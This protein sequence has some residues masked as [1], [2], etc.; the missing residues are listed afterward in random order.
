MADYAVD[1]STDNYIYRREITITETGGEGRTNL[2]VKLLFT[3]SNFNF[4]LARSD[5]YDVRVAVSSNGTGV[6]NMWVVSW[7]K[8]EEEGVIWIKIPSL[9][10]DEIKTLYVYWG[11]TNAEYVSNIDDVG[12]LLADHFD[13][14]SI[15]TS[16]W[17]VSTTPT[18]YG[19]SKIV[20]PQSHYMEAKNTPLSG[21]TDWILEEGASVY[22]P[23]NLFGSPSRK[24][25][26]YGSE[27]NF[28][29]WYYREGN[30]D[31][32][33]NIIDGVNYVYYD[34]TQKGI[35]NT[36][37]STMSVAYSESTDRVYQSMKDRNSYV[38]YMDSWERQVYGETK[39]TYFRLYGRDWQAGTGVPWLATEWIVVREFFETDPYSFDTSNLYVPYETVN[40]EIID[41]TSYDDDVTSVNFYHTTNSGG[42]PY[43]LSDNI[44]SVITNCWYSNDNTAFA[45]SIIDF[46]RDNNNIVSTENTH[47]DSGHSGLKNA[48]RLS[49]NDDNT[50]FQGTTSSGYVCIEFDNN[51]AVGCL[52]VKGLTGSLDNMVKDYIF[53][54]SYDDP[55]LSGD[56]EIFSSGSFQQVDEEQPIYFVNGTPYKY[57][58]LEMLNT[59]G[60]GN[61]ILS[62]WQMYQYDESKRKMTVSQLRLNPVA[63]DS[64]EIYF[65]KAV[66]VEVSDNMLD[67]TELLPLT[68]TVTPF[69]DYIWNRWQRFSFT[70][71]TGYYNYKLICYG[72]WN[73]YSGPMAIAEWEMV[74][75]SSEGHA[76]RVLAGISNDFSSVWASTDTT[77]DEGFIYIGDGGFLNTV[78]NDSLVS[79]TVVSGIVDINLI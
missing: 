69:Y 39:I 45:E 33:H 20:M 18:Y 16:K 37:S 4:R 35:E 63:F 64:Q 50:Y 56:W 49:D 25:V 14:V 31:R 71:E 26:F 32:N 5:G 3:A 12:F 36:G 40:H 44:S 2:S 74:E 42:D 22:A 34:G 29:I 77:F 57:Y 24:H 66:S 51:V 38:D 19:E 52:V 28:Q 61:I 48:S 46:G 79:S 7:D 54:G 41:W 67:W 8:D 43:K 47:Y 65:P 53:M 55:R 23:S 17:T 75:K 15:D 60:A 27:G 68:N 76:H 13:G 30:K 1:I 58:K 11:N 73:G 70:N 6:L 10:A 59:Y 62:S 21:M 72:N 78:Y 9:L